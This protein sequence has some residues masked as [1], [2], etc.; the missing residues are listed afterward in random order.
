MVTAKV[1]AEDVVEAL[2]LGADDYVTK[3]VQFAVALARIRTHLAKRRAECALSES[4][5]RYALAVEGTN[6]GLWD[7]RVG[8][9]E[10]Y[11]S[12]RWR[13]IMGVDA[14]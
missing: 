5:E 12:P 11:Y 4:E 13:E 9:G 14:G 7:W 6:D 3:P 8:T 10:V 1:Q 2:E